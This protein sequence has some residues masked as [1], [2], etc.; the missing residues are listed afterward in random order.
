ME[1]IDPR[2]TAAE[3]QAAQACEA[4]LAHT[5]EPYRGF[6]VLIP[7]RKKVAQLSKTE[8]LWADIKLPYMSVDGRLRMAHDEH[9]ARDAT[10][11]LHTSFVAELGNGEILCRAVVTSSL[12]GEAM[13]HARVNIGGFGVDKTN[14]YENGE[15]SALGRALG[16]LGYGLLG[17]GVA[18]AEEVLQAREQ[19]AAGPQA[20]P[21]RPLPMMSPPRHEDEPAEREPDD[22]PASERQLSYLKHLLAR[23]GTAEHDLAAEIAAAARSS[24]VA[25]SRIG[26]LQQELR[27]SALAGGE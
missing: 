18:S 13:A 26:A 4:A 25:T 11:T 20:T 8:A 23:T 14:P 12:Y 22:R 9:R 2:I 3:E 21:E 24:A 5:E 10:L 7:Q 6:L 27:Q 17:T 16:F 1:R 19:A 15:T